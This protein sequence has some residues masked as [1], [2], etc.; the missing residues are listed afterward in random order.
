MTRP[1]RRLL[2]LLAVACAV[3]AAPAYAGEIAYDLSPPLTSDR[4]SCGAKDAPIDD[5]D[6]YRVVLYRC[7]PDSLV[8]HQ[9]P[10]KPLWIARRDSLTFNLPADTDS[11][12]FTV[13][14]GIQGWTQAWAVDESG[15]AS[16]GYLSDT[17]ATPAVAAP[18]VPP[19]DTTAGIAP[20]FYA[21][22]NRGGQ[23]IVGPRS[24][25]DYYWALA[26]P[27][28]GIP[29]DQWSAEWIGKLVVT[30][31]GAY[32]IY[33]KSEDGGQVFID[34]TMLINRWG[35]Q[36]LTEWSAPVTLMAGEHSLAVYYMANNG[37]SECH[38]SYSGPGVPKQ[39]IPRGA[40][41]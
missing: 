34:G 41:K 24:A 27:Y 26:S 14:D 4:D 37:N 40:L 1:S 22:P 35:V 38:L 29:A 33:L 15:N 16:C 30:T 25:I 13:A 10:L 3:L 17:W 21:E 9:P 5:F 6:H 12:R 36:A 31:S 19:P 2:S 23:A 20:R 39:V 18:P 28:P 7:K 11:V 32:T 8:R